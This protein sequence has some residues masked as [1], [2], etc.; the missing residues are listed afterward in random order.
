MCVCFSLNLLRMSLAKDVW[1][2]LVGATGSLLY[3]LFKKLCSVYHVQ[4]GE[5]R[6]MVPGARATKGRE[7]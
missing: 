5:A 2:L 6:T 4:E 1:P 7:L 3:L